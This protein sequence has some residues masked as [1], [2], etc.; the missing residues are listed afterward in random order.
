MA[1]TPVQKLSITSGGALTILGVVGLVAYLNT[2]RL[3]ATQ[4]TVAVTNAN[5]AR[6]DRVLERTKDA[7]NA[8]RDFIIRGDTAYLRVISVAQ[9]DVEFA[10]DSLRAT[11]E[12][13]PEQRRNLDK[14]APLVAARLRDVRQ[15]IAARQRFGV[16]SALSVLRKRGAVGPRDGAAALFLL[17][18][19][20]ELRVLGERTRFM[21]ATG[22]SATNFILSG[23]LL[24]F[25]LALVA[26]QPLRPSVAH[27]LTQR[28]STTIDPRQVPELTLTL[29]EA[30][31][32]SSDRLRRLQQVVAELD[33]PVAPG[34]VAQALLTRGA[35]PLV[36]SLGIV[37]GNEAGQLAILAALG[38]AGPEFTLGHLLPAS[39]AAPI[40]D[41]LKARDL[42]AI[43]THAARTAA[44]PALG[45]FS[46]DGTTDGAFIAVPLVCGGV[47]HGALLLAFADNRVFS[48]DERAYLATLGR[49]GGESLARAA[50]SSKSA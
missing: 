8:Q 3:T 17:M 43:E 10:L 41:A 2:S 49:L 29:T 50:L 13:D 26:L 25:M 11:T 6:I 46:E 36:A 14:L 48:D 27:R 35:P 40:Q 20:E 16:D 24:A 44:Y 12:D 37:V 4:R 31:K 32:H 5:I 7:E 30:A 1:F 22:R 47:A 39:L 45:R 19:D 9:S 18:R 33:G 38:Q 15:D 21:T 42:I 28:L 34:V 23:T